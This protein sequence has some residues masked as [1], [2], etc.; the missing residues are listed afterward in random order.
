MCTL[1]A[2]RLKA[3][4]RRRRYNRARSTRSKGRHTPCPAFPRTAPT[5][6]HASPAA[7]TLPATPPGQCRRMARNRPLGWLMVITG[8]IGWL[9]S[10]TLVLEKLEVLKDPNHTTVCDVNPVDLLRPGDAD[11]AEL[12][13]RVP[14]HVY[15]HRGVRHHHHRGHGPAVRRHVRAL[16]LGGA[17]GRR[18]PR[19][20]VCG[21]AVV[22]G[23]VRDPHPV[24][25]LHDRL[26][27]HD[28]AVRL[29][30][31]PE[32]Q[33][34]RHPRTRRRGQE[35]WAIRAGSSPRCSTSRSSPPSSSP[36]SRCSPEPQASSNRTPKRA[37]EARFR[38]NRG[39]SVT[40][41]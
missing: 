38:K 39:F 5:R 11:V 18:H 2:C 28:P 40:S 8:A 27:R 29:G 17:P 25:V 37:T 6:R 16:V 33:P 9:A 35:S 7:G 12:G 3:V 32:R 23:P 21:V 22:P 19:L 15:W 1:A 31:H 41:T 14:Q 24:P 20:R 30:D 34:R 26:G 13:V 10:G 4:F 36:S